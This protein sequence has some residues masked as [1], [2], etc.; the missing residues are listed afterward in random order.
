[1]R[2]REESYPISRVLHEVVHRVLSSRGCR[3]G[4]VHTHTHATSVS[5]FT[6]DVL[7]HT[8]EK[9]THT[10]FISEQSA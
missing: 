10:T 1:M 4:V 2:M 3:M 7:C 6:D 9:Y 5:F 8:A